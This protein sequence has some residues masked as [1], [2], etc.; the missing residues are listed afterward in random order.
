MSKINISC[1]CENSDDIQHFEMDADAAFADVKE[2]VIQASRLDSDALM[3]IDGT[4][5]P[6]DENAR[7]RDCTDGT[8]LKL[9]LHRCRDIAV[10]VT[11]R[12]K[13]VN[14][15]FSPSA[16]IA[17][18]KYE[19]AARELGIGRGDIDEYSLRMLDTHRQPAPDTAIGTL[20]ELGNCSIT[21]ELVPEQGDRIVLHVSTPYGPFNGAFRKETR[22]EEVIRFIIEEKG[23]GAGDDFK[24]YHDQQE[25]EPASPLSAYAL[26]D[27]ASLTLLATGSGV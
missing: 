20:T 5:S 22:V 11:F 10:T 21:F 27:E 3:F 6:V 1:H 14:R 26:G 8:D 18:V 17:R 7:V 16:T 24:L 15:R 23:L 4:D 13:S 12:G 19:T 9:C 25:L 2:R